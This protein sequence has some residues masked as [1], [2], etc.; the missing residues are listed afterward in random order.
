MIVT[1]VSVADMH[2]ANCS[3]K[4]SKALKHH[5]EVQ[6]VSVNLLKRLLFVSHNDALS[7]HTIVQDIQQLGFEPTLDGVSASKLPKSDS[8]NQL[9]RRLGVTGICAMQ[10]MMIQIALYAGEFQGMS[11]AMERLL[12]LG[13][14]VFCIP[15]MTYGAIPFFVRGLSTRI[16]MDTPIALAITIAFSVSVYATLTNQGEVYFDSVAMFTF[17]ML[18][19]RFFDQRLRLRLAVEDSLASSLPKYATR[20]ENT[21]HVNVSTKQLKVDDPI[22][23]QHRMSSYR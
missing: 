9:L 19:A 13:S 14:L 12:Q 2:C 8:D 11:S 18:G 21:D 10:V 23:P 17:L 3:S 6:K 5:P 1:T 15:I 22:L 20:I 16:N 4:I 7:A